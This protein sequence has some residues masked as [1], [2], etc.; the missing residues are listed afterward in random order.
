MS[1]QVYANLLARTDRFEEAA[2]MIDKVRE[3]VPRFTIRASIKVHQR[4]FATEDAR[5]A[6]TAGLQKLIDLGY[7]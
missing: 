1:L 5:E 2:A 7:D 3:I 4:V 6:V